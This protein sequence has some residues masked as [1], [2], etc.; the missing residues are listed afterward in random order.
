[1]GSASRCPQANRPIGSALRRLRA[2][3]AHHDA[4]APA[5]EASRSGIRTQRTWVRELP[6]EVR[7][8]RRPLCQVRTSG[9]RSVGMAPNRVTS[10]RSGTFEYWTSRLTSSSGTAWVAHRSPRGDPACSLG[11]TYPKCKV[12]GDGRSDHPTG[13]KRWLGRS[14]EAAIPFDPESP[15]RQN[16]HHEPN[17]GNGGSGRWWGRP[18]LRDPYD[19]RQPDEPNQRCVTH[20]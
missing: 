17:L 12:E 13:S 18:R 19:G 14:P 15:K 8:V 10:Q 1:M 11:T 5:C 9:C 16:P 6:G 7:G 4:G 3:T 20:P 2:T